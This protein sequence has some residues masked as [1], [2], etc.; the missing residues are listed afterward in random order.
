MCPGY[1]SLDKHKKITQIT[2]DVNQP[3][4]SHG[5]QSTAVSNTDIATS[6]HIPH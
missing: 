6:K 4:T 2:N 1:V 5:A 3:K